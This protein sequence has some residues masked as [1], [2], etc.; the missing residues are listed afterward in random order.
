MNVFNNLDIPDVKVNRIHLNVTTFYY[1]SAS[2]RCI[3]K[4]KKE[5]CSFYQH[6]LI[7]SGSVSA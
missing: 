1:S 7:S 2:L 6:K 4:L 3:E 5:R